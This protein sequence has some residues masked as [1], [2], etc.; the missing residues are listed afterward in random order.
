[1]GLLAII[2]GFWGIGDILRTAGRVS[3]AT[4]GNR[5]ISPEEFRQQFNDRVNQLARQLGRSVSLDQ[6]RAIG[7]DRQ[8]LGQMLAESAIDQRAASLK[9]MM[10][11]AEVARRIMDDPSFQGPTGQFDRFRFEQIIR[12]LNYSEARFAAEQRQTYLRRQLLSSLTSRRLS[13]G[14]K[15]CTDSRT[16]SARSTTWCWTATMPVRWRRPRRRSSPS[17]STIARCCSG[18]PSIAKWSC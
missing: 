16:R 7:V 12:Q 14:S 11:D 4:I 17:I 9:L 15:P 10:S 5:E 13:P 1:M 2:F 8:V 6:A 3:V 18:L